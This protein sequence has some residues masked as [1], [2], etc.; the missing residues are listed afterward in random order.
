MS[1]R[2]KARKR[3]LDALYEADLLGT[4][5]LIALKRDS[6]RRAESGEDPMNPYAADLVSGVQEH[7]VRIDE[8]VETY[9]TDWTLERMP[10]VDR[11]VLRIGCF[12]ILWSDIPDAVAIAEAVALATELSTDSSPSFVNGVLARIAEVKPRLALDA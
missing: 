8:I 4:D 10:V 2:H 1:A 3:A 11:N 12:E 7:R 9:A 6:D 5:P